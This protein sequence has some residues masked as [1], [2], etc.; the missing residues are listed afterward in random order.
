LLAAAWPVPA[1]TLGTPRPVG[2]PALA[3]QQP[4]DAGG[5]PVPAVPNNQPPAGNQVRPPEKFEPRINPGDRPAPVRPGDLDVNRPRLPNLGA[6]QPLAPLGT[7]PKPNAQVQQRYQEFVGDIVDPDNTLDVIVG[8]PRLLRF[9]VKPERYQIGDANIADAD[10]PSQKDP[11]AQLE[12]SVLGKQVGTTVLNLWF[13]DP[14][15]ATKQRILSYLVRVLPDTEEKD[16]LERV[17]KQL[18]AEVNKAFPDS[19]VNLTLVGDKL[20]VSGQAKD[21][22]EATQIL[23]IVRANA[24]GQAQNIPVNQVNVNIDPGA[25]GP[26][27]LP[28]QGLQNFLVAGS[29]NIVNLLRIPGEQQVMLRVTVAEIDRAAARSIGL[30]FSLTNNNGVTYLQNLTGGILGGD[31]N[32]NNLPTILDQGQVVLAINALRTLRFARTLA[33]PTLTA[34]NGRPAS[35]QA[36][37]QFPV[38]VVTGFTGAGLQGVSFVPFGVQLQFTPLVTDK[39]RIRL[40]VNAEVST[41]DLQTAQT[42]IN[43]ANVPSLITRNFNTTVELR[44]G[45]TLAVAGLIQTNF[46]ANADRVPFFGDL[47][48]VGQFAGFNRTTSGEQELIVL[49][50][51][52]LVHPLEGREVTA[53]PGSD[54]IEPGDLEF[55][56][57]NR[58]E[59]RR[60]Y[61]YRASART[62]W[63]R[64]VRYRKCEQIF[65]SGPFGHSDNK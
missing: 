32:I 63:D 62:D 12:L 46:G 26:D 54:V 59:G 7:T 22:A 55:Y 23:R 14:N 30:N 36:G 17:Y 28:E 47:P 5:P 64:M 9:K 13:R 16:R 4:P 50:T 27:G 8:R 11:Q 40:T 18:E 58:L 49:I 65:I 21:T 20:V 44:E 2:R 6:P 38:P 3:W 51:P 53:L 48:W 56:L 39:D 60:D 61:D 35:F 1:Q 19:F 15:D 33:E 29:P 45:Q 57:R 41:R 34:M 37:G 42:N 25:V 43:G 31:P 10:P 24:P 52:E